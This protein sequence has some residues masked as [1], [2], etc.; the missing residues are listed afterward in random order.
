MPSL[1]S[2]TLMVISDIFFH[3]SPAGNKSPAGPVISQ[4]SVRISIA[5]SDM[6]TL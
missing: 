5:L 3:G 2:K 1:R 4:T 6:G